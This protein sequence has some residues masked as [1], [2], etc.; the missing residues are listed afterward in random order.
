M[1]FTGVPVTVSDQQAIEIAPPLQGT[2]WVVGLGCCDPITVHRAATLPFNGTIYVAQRFAIDFIQ[3]GPTGQLYSGNPAD[4]TSF[5]YFGAQIRSVADGIVVRALDGLPEQTPG[6]LPENVTAQNVDGN[7]MVV[8]I[9]NGRFAFY[10]HM[11]PNSV[12]F[13]VGDRVRT[14]DVLGLLGNTGRCRCTLSSGSL[15]VT[16]FLTPCSVG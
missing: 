9:G 14:G 7:Y 2:G 11:Q 3:L 5:P 15:L 8:D 13:K 12:K 16:R 4:V 6:K 1:T 10:A